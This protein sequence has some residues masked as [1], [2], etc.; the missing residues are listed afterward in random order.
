MMEANTGAP[1]IP[2]CDF[3]GTIESVGDQVDSARFKIGDEVTGMRIDVKSDGVFR[4]YLA[5]TPASV[6]DSNSPEVIIRKPRSLTLLQSAALPLVYSTVHTG[7]VK[8]GHLSYP[9]TSTPGQEKAKSILILGGSSG[10]G[11][12]AVQMAKQIGEVGGKIVAS[13][14]GANTEFVKA[15]GAAEVSPSRSSHVAGLLYRLTSESSLR[16]SIILRKT[17]F[18][19]H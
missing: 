19:R 3:A 5:I 12:V 11:S 8:H 10:T 7:L 16:P 17:R 13:C 1:K 14:S 2:G 15:L 18:K 4:E 6:D 9:N